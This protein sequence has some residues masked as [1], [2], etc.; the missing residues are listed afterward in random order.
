VTTLLILIAIAAVVLLALL[1]VK[2][3]MVAKILRQL[4]EKVA[5]DR[6]ERDAAD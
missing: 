1:L 3:L 6:A 4:N 2:Q 5:R